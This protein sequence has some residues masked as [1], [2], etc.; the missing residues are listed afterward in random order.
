M[1]GYKIKFNIEITDESG[2]TETHPVNIDNET[3]LTEE[4]TKTIDSVEQAY[5]RLNKDAI[6]EA[7]AKQLELISKKKLNNTRKQKEE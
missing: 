6:R 2:N 1:G 7:V 4:D 5:L 3:H